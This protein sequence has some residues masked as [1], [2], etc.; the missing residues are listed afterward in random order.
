MTGFSAWFVG[1]AVL[2]LA[3]FAL[4]R[5]LR[6]PPAAAG[7]DLYSRALERWLAGDLTGARDLLRELVDREPDRVDPYLQLGILLRS[8]GDARRAAVMHRS[9]AVRPGL[10]THKRVTIGL[11]LVEDLVALGQW[12]EARTVLDDLALHAVASP[13]YH[14]ANFA[15]AHGLG[16]HAAAAEA[17]R[18]GE[19]RVPA[20]ERERFRRSRAAY[21]VDRGLMLARG[22]QLDQ[23]RHW[24]SQARDLPE[25][26]GRS[27]LVRAVVAARAQAPEDAVAAAT[28]GLRDYPSEMAPVLPILQEA[29]LETG[30]FAK[31]IP[32]L[33]TACQTESSPPAL[34][35]ALALLYEKTGR[36]NDAIGVLETKQGDPRLTPDAAAPY[37]RQLASVTPEAP[38]NRL[39]RV[40]TMP[41]QARGWACRTCGRQERELRW[42]CPD[43]RSFDSFGPRA[44]PATKAPE[45]RSSDVPQLREPPRD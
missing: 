40:L 33:E 16:D 17:L 26:R 10:P 4:W 31:A 8:T 6:R 29:L 21:L 45:R 35:V 9:L 3:G 19:K 5:I 39:W 18:V 43:C 23:A 38:F 34:W 14:Y 41:P 20:T 15:V 1:L 12:S 25:A 32:I 27:L 24:L 44:L 37:L 11:E 42:F 13:R 28:E 22:N 36:R 30:Q 2:L 7:E